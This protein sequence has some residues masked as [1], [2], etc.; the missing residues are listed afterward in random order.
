MVRNTYVEITEN[1]FTPIVHIGCC[2]NVRTL[3]KCC[4]AYMAPF[5]MLFAV[6]QPKSFSLNNCGTSS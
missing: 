2:D 6:S 4:I 1:A 5:Y 3:L